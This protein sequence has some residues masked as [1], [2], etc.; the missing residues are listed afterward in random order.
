MSRAWVRTFSKASRWR[1]LVTNF[2]PF[3]DI[4]KVQIDRNLKAI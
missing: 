3:S 1:V 4:I 2:I